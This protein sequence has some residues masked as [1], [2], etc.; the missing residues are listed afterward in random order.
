VAKVLDE[1]GAGVFSQRSLTLPRPQ[2]QISLGNEA[3]P[4]RTDRRLT[5]PDCFDV[6]WIPQAALLG[7][8]AGRKR[9]IDNS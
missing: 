2:T 9:A 1:M 8:A 7:I 5:P 3:M 6:Y 4:D